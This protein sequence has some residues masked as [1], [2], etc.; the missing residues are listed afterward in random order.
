MTLEERVF[1]RKRFILDKLVK[2]GFHKIVKTSPQ[3]KAFIQD[4]I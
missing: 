1:E 3:L 4:T 2:Y